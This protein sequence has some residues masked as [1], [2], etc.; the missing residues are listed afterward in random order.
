VTTSLTRQH[1]RAVADAVAETPG[2]TPQQRHDVATALAT[3]LA[4]FNPRFDRAKFVEAA[5][6]LDPARPYRR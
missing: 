5:I 2:L 4:R 6:A 3:A 1:F